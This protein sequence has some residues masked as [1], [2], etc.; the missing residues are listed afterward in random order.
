MSVEAL[1]GEISAF[2]IATQRAEA[3]RETC[4]VRDDATVLDRLIEN[5]RL[6]EEVALRRLVA[7]PLTTTTDMAIVAGLVVLLSEGQVWPEFIPHLAAKLADGY[8]TLAAPVKGGAP[9]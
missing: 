5:G 4:G 6:A 7:E 2:M 9:C 1:I 3:M 8:L